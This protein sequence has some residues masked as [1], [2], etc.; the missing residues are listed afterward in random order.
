MENPQGDGAVFHIG[1]LEQLVNAHFAPMKRTFISI[2][3]NV[4]LV[5]E[6][7]M[8]GNPNQKRFS[9]MVQPDFRASSTPCG[10]RSAMQLAM[11]ASAAP[12]GRSG[13]VAF[14]IARNRNSRFLSTRPRPGS[15]RQPPSA[16]ILASTFAFLRS[17][18]HH[19]MSQAQPIMR[20]VALCRATLAFR[21]TLAAS[22]CC[23]LYVSPQSS[24]IAPDPDTK[25]NTPK[26]PGT[27][28]VRVFQG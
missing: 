25:R 21:P 11:N 26:L 23:S 4:R 20:R 15:K 14:P 2:G 9:F 22:Q 13:S 16:H 12:R 8:K 1:I 17:S 7:D 5:P 19:L 27:D 10:V 24:D 6:A 28:V 3:I 18:S